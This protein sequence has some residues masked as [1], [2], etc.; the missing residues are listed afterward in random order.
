LVQC[1]DCAKTRAIC[2]ESPTVKARAYEL[3]RVRF[4]KA[5]DAVFA[6]YGGYVCA[7]CGED[8]P[9]FMTL[10]HIDGGGIAHRRVL[11]RGYSFY[12]RLAEQGFPPGLRV[13]CYNCNCGRRTGACPHELGKL[14]IVRK[15][16]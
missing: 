15:E 5:K 6:A 4:Q 10:D 8:T 14:R 3:H 12:V 7:C 11:G 1:D 9:E 13:L 16:V 2:K